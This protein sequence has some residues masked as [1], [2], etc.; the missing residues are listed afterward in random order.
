MVGALAVVG[1][2]ENLEAAH[3]AHVAVEIRTVDAIATLSDSRVRTELLPQ[4]FVVL[5]RLPVQLLDERDGGLS[6]H[7]LSCWGNIMTVI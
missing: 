3:V 1:G 7:W 6:L 5:R 2:M 4:R